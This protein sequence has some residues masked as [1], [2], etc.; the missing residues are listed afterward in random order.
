VENWR[1]LGEYALQNPWRML[2]G[3]GY[4]TLPYSN[5]LGRNVVADNMY[6]SM[7][8]ET[9]VVGL[10]A[11]LLFN[12]RILQAGYRAARTSFFGTWIFCFWTGQVVQMVSGDLL[13]YWRVL[14]LY[15]W[16][17]AV[18]VRETRTLS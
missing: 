16:A 18:A 10:G 6:F 13:T 12:F 5:V 17:L 1:L 3:I 4:K 2:I 9:G 8:V 14:P 11:L 7:L 15:L